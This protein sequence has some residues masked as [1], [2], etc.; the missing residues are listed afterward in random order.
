M[1]DI[2]IECKLNRAC[3]SIRSR[4]T[5]ADKMY[6]KG[7]IA[8]VIFEWGFERGADSLSHSHSSAQ[9]DCTVECVFFRN[10]YEFYPIFIWP[11][12][13]CLTKMVSLIF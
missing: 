10:I 2:L 12:W 13:K 1:T 8:D 5:I 3:N 9:I 11:M 4:H 6:Y 7:Y